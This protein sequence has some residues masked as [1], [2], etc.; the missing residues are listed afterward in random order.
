[1]LSLPPYP[2]SPEEVIKGE[3]DGRSQKQGLPGL[4][5]GKIT[6]NKKKERRENRWW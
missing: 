3:E 2:V 5:K 4:E 6:V 1:V